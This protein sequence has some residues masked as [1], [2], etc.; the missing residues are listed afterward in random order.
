[1][2]WFFILIQDNQVEHLNV[3]GWYF[4]MQ[5][6]HETLCLTVMEQYN[7]L[8]IHN[9]P[10]NNKLCNILAL[11]VVL[12]KQ[13]DLPLLLNSLRA[14]NIESFLTPKYLLHLCKH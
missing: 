14:D 7:H 10:I 9:S 12:H 1:M 2:A 13:Q 11:K 8:I 4:L 3:P 6:N 5:L